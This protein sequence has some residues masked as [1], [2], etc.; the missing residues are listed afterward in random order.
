M[1]TCIY[2]YIYEYNMYIYIYS[3]K[4]V[5]V[6]VCVQG[7]GMTGR[8]RDDTSWQAFTDSRDPYAACIN[9]GLIISSLLGCD[10]VAAS[11]GEP[12]PEA[13][14]TNKLETRIE[15]AVNEVLMLVLDQVKV[16]CSLLFI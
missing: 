9:L 15:G 8:L 10:A 1:Y 2:V 13:I 16:S 5:F 14:R 4:P 7:M 11:R 3:Y 6:C 12:E